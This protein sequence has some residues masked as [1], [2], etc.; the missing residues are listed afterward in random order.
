MSIEQ[1][2]PTRGPHPVEGF[3]VVCVQCTILMIML[4]GLS[5]P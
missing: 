2:C 5:A 4:N 3:V 1:L